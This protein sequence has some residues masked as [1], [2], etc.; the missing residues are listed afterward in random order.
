MFEHLLYCKHCQNSDITSDFTVLK[1]CK[2]SDLYSLD[3]M[4]I[5]EQ[6]PKLKIKIPSNEKK[7][8]SI[9]HILN[10]MFFIF[11]FVFFTLVFMFSSI[12]K[13]YK[14][15]IFTKNFIF[16]YVT[17][18]IKFKMVLIFKYFLI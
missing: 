2:K 1:R 17:I 16:S 13:F 10:L 4:L 8:N 14:Q 18:S 9:K 3:S 7:N 15:L 6:N 11:C 5:E 12:I